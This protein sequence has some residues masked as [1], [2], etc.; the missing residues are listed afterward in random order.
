MNPGDSQDM[1]LWCRSGPVLPGLPGPFGSSLGGPGIITGV[2]PAWLMQA[3][4][5]SLCSKD[6][7]L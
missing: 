1:A 5:L 4:V 7:A 2:S 6:G 3:P